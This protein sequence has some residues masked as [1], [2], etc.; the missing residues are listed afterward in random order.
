MVKSCR[1]KRVKG[2]GLTFIE[3]TMMMMVMHIMM[4]VTGMRKGKRW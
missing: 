1:G 2:Q 4:V 3:P